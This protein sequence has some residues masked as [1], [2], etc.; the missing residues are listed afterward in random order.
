MISHALGYVLV[1]VIAIVPSGCR[2]SP[3]QTVST[4]HR[5]DSNE[6]MARAFLE[7]L[8]TALVASGI[9]GLCQAELGNSE[10]TRRQQPARGSPGRTQGR[11]AGAL[12]PGCTSAVR[13]QSGGSWNI[14]AARRSRANRVLAFR[15][16]HLGPWPHP[17][18]S[19]HLHGGLH[20]GGLP[21]SAMVIF[22]SEGRG[23]GSL[24]VSPRRDA[25]RRVAQ[26][27]PQAV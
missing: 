22:I 20:S 27:D 18:W 5:I 14:S 26:S 8:D 13:G 19:G 2:S 6:E 3:A 25:V 21:S 12:A 23:M 10:V 11:Q 16:L 17:P 1:A 7:V 9:E 24:G 15:G 4:D